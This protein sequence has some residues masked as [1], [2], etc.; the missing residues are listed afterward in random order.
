MNKLWH[1]KS[2]NYSQIFNINLI[3]DNIH[4]L[5]E[6]LPPLLKLPSLLN[7][8]QDFINIALYQVFFIDVLIFIS[9]FIFCFKEIIY[10]NKQIELTLN[11]VNEIEDMLLYEN[12]L[13]EKSP[14]F[15]S[16]GID[17]Q[18]NKIPLCWFS[19]ESSSPKSISIVQFI[20]RLF[21][22]LH[23]LEKY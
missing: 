22:F 9:N 12:L 16:I 2:L 7:F 11:D 17:L 13:I 21:Y 14:R 19:N 4:L 8:K 3:H 1:E 5:K 20:H 10:F 23:S 6:R 18:K 15:K